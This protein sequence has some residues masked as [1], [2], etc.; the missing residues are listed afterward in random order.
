[1]PVSDATV[2]SAEGVTGHLIYDMDGMWY[3]RVYGDRK[4]G[5]FTDYAIF[6]TDMTVTITDPDAFFYKKDSGMY[7]NILDHS[8]ETLGIEIK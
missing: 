6:H 7:H 5:E 1:M 2:K 4:A 3:F 8:P